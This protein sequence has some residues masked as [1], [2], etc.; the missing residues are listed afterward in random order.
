MGCCGT[1]GHIYLVVVNGLFMVSVDD[2]QKQYSIDVRNEYQT[3]NGNNNIFNSCKIKLLKLNS[4]ISKDTFSVIHVYNTYNNWCYNSFC[5]L[6]NV[7]FSFWFISC[8]YMYKIL[9]YCFRKF[10]EFFYNQLYFFL[11]NSICESMQHN[12]VNFPALRHHVDRAR[13]RDACWRHLREPESS[14]P[15]EDAV[16]RELQCR[17]P[18]RRPGHRHGGGRGSHSVHRHPGDMWGV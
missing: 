7:I 5:G 14:A 4:N 10:F 15:D 12:I 8:N 13:G 16:R 9:N 18:C 3:I 6:Q 1:L 11:R 17:R 2:S